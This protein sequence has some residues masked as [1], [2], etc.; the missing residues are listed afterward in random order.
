MNTISP[1]SFTALRG[2]VNGSIAATHAATNA[3]IISTN[4]I[5]CRRA[6][7]P[8]AP[9][10]TSLADI[11]PNSGGIAARSRKINPMPPAN[12]ASVIAKQGIKFLKNFV[13]L[14]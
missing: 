1:N 3:E 12:T 14:E 2:E 4:G 11:V 7:Q 8:P 5:A 9:R 6:A 13:I 10:A